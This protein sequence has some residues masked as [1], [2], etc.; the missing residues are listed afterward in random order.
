[1]GRG[2][3]RAANCL[4]RA[5]RLTRRAHSE[6]VDHVLDVAEAVLGT[7]ALGPLLDHARRELARL[8]AAATDQV[9]VVPLHRA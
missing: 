4:R 1:M 2:G 6:Q 5:A 3:S 7:D 8:A 9:M